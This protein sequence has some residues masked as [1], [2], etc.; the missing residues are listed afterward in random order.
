MSSQ[1]SGTDARFGSSRMNEL[2]SRLQ[3]LVNKYLRRILRIHWPRT[4][5]NTRLWEITDQQPIDKD[6]LLRNCRW[7]GHL[8]RK[9]ENY[10]SKQVLTWQTYGSRRP[11]PY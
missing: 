8:L 7:I 4:I 2:T 11:P 6:I 10:I 1:S 3:V 5:S 9:P